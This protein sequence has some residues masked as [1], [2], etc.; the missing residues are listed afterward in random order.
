MCRMIIHVYIKCTE[1]PKHYVCTTFQCNEL[2]TT[3]RPLRC[4]E[5][6]TQIA[7]DFV[8]DICCPFCVTLI[9]MVQGGKVLEK[10]VEEGM[11]LSTC[12]GIPMN[13]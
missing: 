1:G 13:F 7:H 3:P 6:G 2:E 4:C 5:S 9:S 10:E 8:E 12:Y 11:G